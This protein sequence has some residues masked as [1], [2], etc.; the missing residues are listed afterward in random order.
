MYGKAQVGKFL[1]EPGYDIAVNLDDM[2]MPEMRDQWSGQR[3]QSRTDFD[4]HVSRLRRDCRQDIGDDC[5]VDQKILAKA[6][7]GNVPGHDLANPGLSAV[8]VGAL[9]A[10]P[11]QSVRGTPQCG[12]AYLTMQ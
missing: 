2:Q 4:G 3:A 9:V 12:G 8:Q 7:A 11:A 5:L 10:N 6:F 1:P